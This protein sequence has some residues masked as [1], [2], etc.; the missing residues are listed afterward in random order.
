MFELQTLYFFVSDPGGYYN[1][2][3][4]ACSVLRLATQLL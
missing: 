4:A 2:V 1:I 3:G